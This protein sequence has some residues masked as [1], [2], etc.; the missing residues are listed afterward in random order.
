M[1]GPV[2]ADLMQMDRYLLNGCELRLKFHQSSDQ[3]RLVTKAEKLDIKVVQGMYGK[4]FS[5]GYNGTCS[6]TDKKSSFMSIR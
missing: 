5:R 6:N 2:Y 1:E 4:S 3:F